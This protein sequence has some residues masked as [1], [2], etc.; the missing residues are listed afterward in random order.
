MTNKH[1]PIDALFVLRTS[2]EVITDIQEKLQTRPTLNPTNLTYL[3][4]RLSL[5]DDGL[6]IGI[7]KINELT[8]Y[9]EE[10]QNTLSAAEHQAS[11]LMDDLNDLIKGN[12]ALTANE[13]ATIAKELYSTAEDL[14]YFLGAGVVQ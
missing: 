12:K 4:S 2:Q 9:K 3:Q 13:V 1:A 11:D 14:Y 6:E 8:H 10:A 7:N 5:V